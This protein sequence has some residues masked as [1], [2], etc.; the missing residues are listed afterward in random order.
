MRHQELALFK[1]F[2]NN[3]V[4]AMIDYLIYLVVSIFGGW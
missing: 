4:E 3:N 1:P 2:L